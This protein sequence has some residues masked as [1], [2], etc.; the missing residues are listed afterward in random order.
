MAYFKVNIMG[1][2][3]QFLQYRLALHFFRQDYIMR[4]S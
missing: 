3:D 2:H 4:L 1:A